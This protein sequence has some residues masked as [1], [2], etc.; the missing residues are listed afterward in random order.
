M[1]ARKHFGCPSLHGVEAESQNRIHLNEYI[2]GV[3]ITISKI[4]T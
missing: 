3:R 4:L 1:E 2:Y